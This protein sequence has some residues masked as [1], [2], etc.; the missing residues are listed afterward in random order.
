[1]CR[2]QDG[3]Y[4]DVTVKLGLVKL[5]HKR[6]DICEELSKA[7]AE[8]QCPVEP[9]QYTITQT[10]ELPREIPRAKFVVQTRAFTVEDEDLACADVVR[11]EPLATIVAQADDMPPD[12]RLCALHT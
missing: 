5:L 9:G 7:D 11:L 12:D 4:A 6:F 10:V 2:A 1:L 8:L 3:A